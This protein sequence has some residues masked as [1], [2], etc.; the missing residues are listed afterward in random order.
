MSNDERIAGLEIT[1]KHID[2]GLMSVVDEMKRNAYNLDLRLD[3]M[4]TKINKRIDDN[5]NLLHSGLK[6]INNR[7]WTNFTFTLGV[8]AAVFAIMAHGFHWF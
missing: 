4:T 5:F 1:I 6:D 7:L 8:C 3:D 2:K